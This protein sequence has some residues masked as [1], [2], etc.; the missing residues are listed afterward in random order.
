MTEV[1]LNA[2]DP[3]PA[4]RSAK[5]VAFHAG[6]AALMYHTPLSVFVPAAFI[7]AALRNGKRA[8]WLAIAGASILLGMIAPAIASSASTPAILSS[9][10]RFIFEVGIPAGIVALLVIRGLPFGQVLLS[11]VAASFAGFAVTEMAMRAL[12]NY[13]PYSMILGNF[14][15]IAQAAVDV[16]RKQGWPPETIRAMETIS[17]AVAETFLPGLLLSMTVTMFALSLIM[18]PRL[19][20]G[21]VTGP[22]YYLRN[23]S[24]PDGLLFGF[25]A[26]GLA[27]LASGPLR[28]I[29]LN[30]LVIVAF[31][32]FLQGLGILRSVLLQ[33]GFG[34]LGTM[35]TYL[36]VAMLTVYGVAPLALAIV[37]LF[38][39]FFDFRKLH[40]KETSD[41]SDS[42]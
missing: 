22:T 40:R 8:M 35:I 29:L 9:L 32:Y 25:I 24:F 1:V 30:L 39:S 31:L 12:M 6:L 10:S 13:S 42:D 21:K 11:G 3:R 41:E 34:P 36:V 16:Y 14:R 2:T 33:L 20:A 26:G 4:G 27:P 18:I 15:A 17:R 5:S 23:L 37:G 38:D 7:H 28:A 19:P